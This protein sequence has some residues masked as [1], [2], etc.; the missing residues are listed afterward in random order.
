MDDFCPAFFGDLTLEAAAAA[1]G[2]LRSVDNEVMDSLSSSSADEDDEA[3]VCF[4][5]ETVETVEI[6]AVVA[7]TAATAVAL[8]VVVVLSAA[9]RGVLCA[10]AG[11]AV[12]A[13]ASFSSRRCTKSAL[14]PEVDNSLLL[15]C[16]LSSA[17][18]NLEY[19]SIKYCQYVLK[20]GFRV[21]SLKEK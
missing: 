12:S 1:D 6:V 5:E 13:A 9:G 14:T 16:S 18:L 10:G 20:D 19:C 3:S 4:F 17:T 15:K 21:R 2:D 8:L 7:A 11:E